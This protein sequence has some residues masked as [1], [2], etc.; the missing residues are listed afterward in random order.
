MGTI[1]NF[2]RFFHRLSAK[3]WEKICANRPRRDAPNEI[4][5]TE[6]ALAPV[7]RALVKDVDSAISLDQLMQ[8]T[9][10][11]D[12]L[13]SAFDNSYEYHAY[14]LMQGAIT[15]SLCTNLM[16]LFERN[17]RSW[18]TACFSRILDRLTDD[19]DDD[20]RLCIRTRRA[21]HVQADQVEREV[22]M[23]MDQLAD[24]KAMNQQVRA[25]HQLQRVKRFRDSV[26]AHTS[27]NQP[28]RHG[29]PPP[30]LGDLSYLVERARE[31]IDRISGPLIGEGHDF[32]STA[33]YF[34]RFSESFSN[35]LALG[36]KQLTDSGDTIQWC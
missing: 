17:P 29:Q 16:R 1:S 13:T 33:E 22:A 30:Q 7:I 31:I 24:A 14:A 19:A 26:I 27:L 15:Y 4:P 3:V 5:I 9:H 35:A 6:E 32:Q 20:F 36:M 23:A 11:G 28:A 8:A 2:K 12:R 18:D 34:G 10:Y 25:S 21:R